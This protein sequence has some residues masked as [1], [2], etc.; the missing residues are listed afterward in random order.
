MNKRVKQENGIKLKDILS[1]KGYELITPY[2]GLHNKVKVICLT[3]GEF[4]IKP[5]KVFIGQGC[6]PCGKISSI[7][8]RTK[9]AGVF[10]EELQKH[11][12]KLIGKYINNKTGIEVE[13]PKHGEFSCIPNSFISGHGCPTCGRE[14]GDFKR[15]KNIANVNSEIAKTNYKLLSEVGLAHDRITL[16]C[17]FLHSPYTVKA[18]SFIQGIRCPHCVKRISDPHK[19]IIDFIKSIYQKQILINDRTQL[20]GL[21]LDIWVPEANFGIEFDGLY[22]HSER[23]NPDTKLKNKLKIKKV[24]EI[25]INFLA[26]FSDEWDNPV[27]QNI[28]KSMIAFRLGII[29]NKIYARNTILEDVSKQEAKDFME[30]NHLDG[31]VLCRYAKGLR[32]KDGK[33]IMCCTFRS[34]RGGKLELARMASLAGYSIIGGA[35]KILSSVTE[36]LISYSNNRLSKGNVYEQ[37]GFKEITETTAPSY[38]YTDDKIR[39]W[40]AKCMKIKGLPGTERDQAVAGAFAKHFG[41]SRP[42][43]QIYDYGHRKWLLDKS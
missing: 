27:K 13:C 37:L 12:F 36:P 29:S 10:Q 40:R 9:S 18:Y 24:Q 25:G 31:S 23:N 14:K 42:V 3:H 43:Y 7:Q 19:E 16:Q 4:L 6:N 41:H 15:R 38:Y 39:V 2:S 20:K 11:G 22:W 35:S 33:L 26:I 34:S 21:E 30:L 28:V 5:S 1:S 32:N 8:K 17:P